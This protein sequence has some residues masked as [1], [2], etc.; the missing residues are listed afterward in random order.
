MSAYL[1]GYDS[2]HMLFHQPIA[3]GPLT[4]EDLDDDDCFS[5]FDA[6]E[7]DID[8][9][10]EA[11]QHE[12]PRVAARVSPP[13]PSS[14]PRTIS[15]RMLQVLQQNRTR[16]RAAAAG[17]DSMPPRRRMP[18]AVEK[19]VG[20]S[21]ADLHSMGN[22]KTSPANTVKMT[23]T[24][25]D[26]SLSSRPRSSCTD[27]LEARISKSFQTQRGNGLGCRAV[28]EEP[29][30]SLLYLE[31]ETYPAE[32]VRKTVHAR[33][34]DNRSRNASTPQETKMM[35]IM[36]KER[37]MNVF[38]SEM[39]CPERSSSAKKNNGVMFHFRRGK[40]VKNDVLDGRLERLALTN[41]RPDDRV[42]NTLV[43]AQPLKHVTDPEYTALALQ[44]AET[45]S[46][47]DSI[48]S[49]MKKPSFLELAARV[50]NE[51]Q[52][53]LKT[54]QQIRAN[55]TTLIL[56]S[57]SKRQNADFTQALRRLVAKAASVQMRIG[58]LMDAIKQLMV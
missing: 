35:E 38:R 54:T 31:R 41:G 13:S 32:S 40:S 12:K 30:V 5:D 50:L 47:V 6:V 42:E 56:A 1:N 18:R 4:V 10:I 7:R 45:E 33:L 15:Q 53:L 46:L 14:S 52:L 20:N 43:K 49:C 57:V 34:S 16:S 24:T 22:K 8:A 58:A 17:A 23:D 51:M 3:T 27:R 19:T 2:E 29:D 11:R 48:E 55:G 44:L 26:T 37:A 9:E 21:A 28:E 39:S 25:L 36:D